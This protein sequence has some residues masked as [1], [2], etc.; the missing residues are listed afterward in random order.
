LETSPVGLLLQLSNEM[1]VIQ[2]EES[3]IFD[4]VESVWGFAIIWFSIVLFKLTKY[5]NLHQKQKAISAEK[6][7]F[8]DSICVLLAKMEGVRKGRHAN[9]LGSLKYYVKELSQRAF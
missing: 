3:N 5:L 2:I 7:D 6:I 9:E 4:L 8:R 1:M